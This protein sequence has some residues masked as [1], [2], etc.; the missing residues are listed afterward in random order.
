MKIIVN[1][2]IAQQLGAGQ[3]EKTEDGIYLPRQK[4]LV[5]GRF[6]HQLIRN[7][8]MSPLEWDG[9][10]VV[11]QFLEHLLDVSL[12][13]G[14]PITS[15]YVGLFK[16]NYTP[17]ATDTGA[18]IAANSTELTEYDEANRVSWV[19]AG[20][21]SKAITNAASKAT[22]TINA[23]VTAYGSFLAS[24]NTKGDS[25]G[26]S[27]LV[28]AAKFASSRALVD[29]DQLLVTYEIGAADDGV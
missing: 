21:A 20:V 18:N 6:G 2:A 15:W 13:G 12:S 10:I 7:G 24:N 14:T 16:G 5:G 22:F 17:L 9:N 11:D 23:T 28:A 25:T 19:E 3:F 4:M 8:E 29:D 1:P 27:V 26:S